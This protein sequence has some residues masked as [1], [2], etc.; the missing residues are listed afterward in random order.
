MG[1]TAPTSAHPRTTGQYPGQLYGV[2]GLDGRMLTRETDR[3]ALP[4]ILAI[5]LDAQHTCKAVRRGTTSRDET[6]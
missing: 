1:A 4:H 2:S 5:Q 3:D 6:Q